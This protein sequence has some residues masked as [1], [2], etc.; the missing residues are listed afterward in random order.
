[1]SAV[2]QA[3]KTPR[4]NSEAPR[5]FERR[6]KGF[7]KLSYAETFYQLGRLTSGKAEMLCVL[8]VLS[9]TVSA[10]RAPKTAGPKTSKRPITI[11]EFAWY[12]GTDTRTIDFA[13]AR[14]V[15]AGV[16]LK[17]QDPDGLHYGAA[18][19]AWP[20]LPDYAVLK[21]PAGSADDPDSNDDEDPDSGEQE[22]KDVRSG[23]RVSEYP[24]VVKKGLRQKAL[25]LP[26][27][28]EKL[29]FRSTSDLVID[30]V[31][32][33]GVL[34][35]MIQGPIDGARAAT[36][37]EQ[38]KIARS[39]LRAEN[40]QATHSVRSSKT[41]VADLHELLDDYFRRHYGKLP[42]KKLLERIRAELGQAGLKQFQ[43]VC[44]ARFRRGG[45]IEPGLFVEL[46]KDA[47]QA[48]NGSHGHSNVEN[49][50]AAKERHIQFQVESLEYALRMPND[51][52]ARE[53]LED[54]DP[55]L[56]EQA[57]A[58]VREAVK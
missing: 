10:A 1:M 13:I 25:P 56:L 3:L 40:G 42:D 50:T 53:L 26:A 16:L 29:K 33:G 27:P 23:L 31:I 46:A 41:T 38:A 12:A 54:A 2:A 30:P 11:E 20:K 35:V 9:E 24:I 48:A 57:R 45:D 28:V 43:T 55:E 21:K 22:A 14:L 8:Y 52:T 32:Q 6:V 34:Y 58:R 49:S 39:G 15:T 36:G 4:K 47:A 5:S 19:D 17:R 51:P 7:L 18:I 37:E 44:F